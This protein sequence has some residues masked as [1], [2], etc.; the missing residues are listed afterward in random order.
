MIQLQ[1]SRVENVTVVEVAGRI[2]A[3][4]ATTLQEALLDEIDRGNTNLVLDLSST[5]FIDSTGLRALVYAYKRVRRIA[6]DVRLVQPSYPVHTILQLTGLASV[7]RTYPSRAE[8]VAS[9]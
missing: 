9:Y 5:D 2:A 3:S 7:F 4:D 6:G 8:A 1:I